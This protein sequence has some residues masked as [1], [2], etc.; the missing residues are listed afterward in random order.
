M[1]TTNAVPFTS[2]DP[3][4]E[5]TVITFE[6]REARLIASGLRSQQCQNRA[7]KKRNPLQCVY[8]HLPLLAQDRTNLIRRDP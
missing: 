6:I 5:K 7:G 3:V 4:A 1:R 2:L 8:S